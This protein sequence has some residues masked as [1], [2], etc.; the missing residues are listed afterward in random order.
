MIISINY[1][2]N[3]IELLIT[4]LLASSI[5]KIENPNISVIN[6]IFLDSYVVLYTYK[7][8]EIP[9]HINGTISI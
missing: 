2:Q 9:S 4:M 1:V 8:R 3:K 5:P 6:K 7:H